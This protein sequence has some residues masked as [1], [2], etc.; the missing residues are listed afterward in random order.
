MCLVLLQLDVPWL[1]DI[2]GRSPLF[3]RRRGGGVAGSEERG[4]GRGRDR[5]ERRGE[6]ASIQM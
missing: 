2:S 3:Q 1:V 6:E 4:E 5:E